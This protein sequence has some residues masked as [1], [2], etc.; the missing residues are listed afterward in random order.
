MS[1]P[2]DYCSSDDCDFGQHDADCPNR[3]AGLL[4]ATELIVIRATDDLD[5]IWAACEASPLY[6]D[7]LFTDVCDILFATRPLI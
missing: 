6:H 4:L 7:R 1:D 3:D 5:T 2:C